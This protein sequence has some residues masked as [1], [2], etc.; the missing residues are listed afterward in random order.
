MKPIYG[1][2]FEPIDEN[3]G[4]YIKSLFEGSVVNAPTFLLED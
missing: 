2:L 1:Y 3:S 4:V